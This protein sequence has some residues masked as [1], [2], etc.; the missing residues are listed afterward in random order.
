MFQYPKTIENEAQLDEIL[1][2]PDQQLIDFMKRLDGDIAI[3]GIGGKMGPTLGR[4]AV[5]AI[6]AAGV[7]KNVY[8][9][10]RFS[11]AAANAT[12]GAVLRPSGSPITFSA[13]IGNNSRVFSTKSLLVITRT[14]SGAIK[15]K[16]RCTVSSINGFSLT[17][18]KNCFGLFRLPAGQKRSPLPPAIMTA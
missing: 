1:S 5:N 6:K 14:F 8:G 11:N 13:G 3:L 17:S 18:G 15:G 16:R 2:M 7:N 12:Q 10:S 4:L 9:V